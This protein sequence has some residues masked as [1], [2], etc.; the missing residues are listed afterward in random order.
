VS[1]AAYR[2]RHWFRNLLVRT[3]RPTSPA[4]SFVSRNYL[5][6]E[7][8]T[9]SATIPSG[10]ALKSLEP[11]GHHCLLKNRAVP[12]L[13]MSCSLPQR[14]I[15]CWTWHD[16]YTHD[17]IAAVVNAAYDTGSNPRSSMKTT[18]YQER[19]MESKSGGLRPWWSALS[20]RGGLSGQS[21]D[22]TFRCWRATLRFD[23]IEWALIST[24]VRI[25]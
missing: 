19:G 10:M 18:E 2:H 15:T 24:L 1:C 16:F 3:Y 8:R 14:S 17:R 6:L 20:Q 11:R 22:W 25:G 4:Q 23:A 7:S 12:Q 21:V 5:L 13:V 9:S